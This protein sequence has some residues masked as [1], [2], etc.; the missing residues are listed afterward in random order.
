MD[1]DLT[2]DQRALRDVVRD[3]A[4]STLTSGYLDRAQRAEFPWPEH[5]QVAKLGA[6]GLL[7]GPEWGGEEAPDFELTGIVMEELAYADFNIANCVL[8]PLI[9]TSILR[10]F[11][12]RAMQEEWMPGLVDGTQLVALGLTEPGSGSDAAAM[13][14]TAVRTE[15]GWRINGEKTSVTAIP[16]ARAAVIFA[17]TD[18]S[19]GAKG[20]SAFLVPLDSSGVSMGPIDDFGWLPVGRGSI[21]MQNVEVPYEALIGGEGEAFRTVMN[22][23]DFTR[24]LLALT[25]L[26]AAAAS[27]DETVEYVQQREA[28]GSPLAKFEGI[29]FPLAEHATYIDTA[30]MLCYRTLWKRTKGLPHTADAA[31]SKWLGPKVAY[32]AIT[33][34]LLTFGHYGYSTQFPHTQRLRDVLAVQIADGTAQVQKIVIA[35]E[36]FGRAFVPY[37]SGP[38]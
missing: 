15:H 9:I 5:Q 27:L 4:R 28:F 26:G 3:F 13:R 16:F 36:L 14:S 29:S 35:R 11:G 19:A 8:P 17:K 25:G 37:A 7:A 38:R 18:K 21:S 34:C 20:V 23:F 30:R 6:L 10:E 12:S 33:A 2:P 24:P 1:F 32:D 31:Q 22:N